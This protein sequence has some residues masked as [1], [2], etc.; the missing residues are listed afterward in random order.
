M[1]ARIL[2]I[3]LLAALAGC[4][5]GGTDDDGR[6]V[7]RLPDDSDDE[8]ACR[9]A[10]DALNECVVFLD[11]NGDEMSADSIARGCGRDPVDCYADCYDPGGTCRQWHDCLTDECGL[12]A[13]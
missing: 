8:D 12:D 4:I 1:N 2:F 7:F 6:P 11:D 5:A 3:V 9:D 13:S 10:I